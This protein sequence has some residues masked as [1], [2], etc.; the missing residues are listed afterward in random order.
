MT[1][2]LIRTRILSL[3]RPAA[4]NLPP[5]G[6]GVETLRL[7]PGNVR[8]EV[9]Y[10]LRIIT[11][12]QVAARLLGA[13]LPISNGALARLARAWAGFKDENRRDQAEIVHQC[14]NVPPDQP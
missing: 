10:D 6:H 4:G 2:S 12:P 8:L 11:L 1:V 5:P 3:S 7:L 13:G 9:R 14:C